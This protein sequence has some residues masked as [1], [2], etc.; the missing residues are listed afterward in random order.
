MNVRVET[1]RAPSPFL[2]RTAIETVLRG[3]PWP[4]GPERT[5]ADAVASAVARQRDGGRP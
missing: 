3:G 1:D 5:V 2:L 4:A